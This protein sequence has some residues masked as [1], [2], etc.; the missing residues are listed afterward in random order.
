LSHQKRGDEEEPMSTRATEN[1][2]EALDGRMDWTEDERV[3]AWRL[4]SL[5]RVGYDDCAAIDLAENREVDL[6][7]ACGLLEGG[8]P[9]ATALRILL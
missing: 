6:H 8:C 7:L 2:I 9:V 1:P 3:V 5:L 4:E